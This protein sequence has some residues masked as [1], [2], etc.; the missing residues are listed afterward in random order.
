MSRNLLHREKFAVYADCEDVGVSVDMHKEVKRK[1]IV[2]ADAGIDVSSSSSLNSIVDRMDWG[3]WLPAAADA[4]NISPNVND[5]VLKPTIICPTDLPNRN[6]VGFPL[7]E[8]TA[9]DMETHMQ[10]YKGWKGCPTFSD[11]D[12]TDP[13]KARGVVVDVIIKPVKG[14]Q[15][16]IWKVFGLAAFDRSKYPDVAQRI[17]T[18]ERRTVSMGAYVESY[19]CSICNSEVGKCE[20]TSNSRHK[21]TPMD[22][23]LDPV[24]GKLIYRNCIGITP[25]E[26]SEVEVPAWSVS[27]MAD[28]TFK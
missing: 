16:N 22:F 15:G 11:H 26:L 18:G 1:N 6:G 10:V 12:N 19:A 5:Y 25:F 8:L 3:T 7:K 17:L 28:R 24:T 2:V 27:E 23:G 20:H 9:W 13:L 21:L 4:Y 14:Y